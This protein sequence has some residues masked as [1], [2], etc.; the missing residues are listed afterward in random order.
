MN[1][2]AF[3]ALHGFGNKKAPH[4]HAGPKKRLVYEIRCQGKK[5]LVKTQA[6]VQIIKR[7]IENP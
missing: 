5:D 6:C 1:T 2:A 4:E 3:E 7:F